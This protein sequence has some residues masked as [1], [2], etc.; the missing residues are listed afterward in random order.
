MQLDSPHLLKR[1][2]TVHGANS[3]SKKTLG[4][5][6]LCDN[7]P[8]FWSSMQQ[9]LEAACAG[10]TGAEHVAQGHAALQ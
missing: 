10:S 8:R 9:L 1:V 2:N 4:V 7:L 3:V 6:Q 5:S